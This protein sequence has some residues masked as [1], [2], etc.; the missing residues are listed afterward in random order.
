ME[1][2]HIT[3]SAPPK[4]VWLDHPRFVLN[5]WSALNNVKGKYQFDLQ[6]MTKKP[7]PK[8][9]VEVIKNAP[10]AKSLTS[11]LFSSAPVIKKVK[12][13]MLPHVMMDFMDHKKPKH[14]VVVVVLPT[15]VVYYNMDIEVGSM[16]EE[17]QIKL[18]GPTT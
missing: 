13:W 2:K 1:N 12:D 3:E 14:L 9:E 17:V 7:P 10:L 8:V 15:G 5:F 18:S 16:Q 11:S 6:P 4:K